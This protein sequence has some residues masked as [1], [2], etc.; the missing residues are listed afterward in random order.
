MAGKTLRELGVKEVEPVG[1]VSVKAS[2]FPFSKFPG[3]DTILGP[4]MKSTGEVMGIH[5]NFGGAFA[6][7]QFASNTTLPST[8]KVFLSI[9]DRDKEPLPGMVKRLSDLGFSVVATKGSAQFLKEH[10]LDVEVVNKVR[11]G[12]PHIVDM[13]GRGEIVMVINTPEGWQPVMDS[14]SI[15]IVA[16]E[17]RIPTYTT[18][19]AGRAV[20]EALQMVKD[21]SYLSVRALQ[22]YLRPRTEQT[23]P[24]AAS[25]AMR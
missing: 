9:R 22:D 23:V 1:Y 12:S 20:S 4:E 11:E 2:V 24:R 13:L 15:R 21:K 10:G 14:K 16:N 18:I 5:A 25:A 19:A 7:S 6:K 3:V 8:G 17:M